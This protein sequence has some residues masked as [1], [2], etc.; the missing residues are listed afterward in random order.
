MLFSL[1]EIKPT[2]VAKAEEIA[3]YFI[4]ATAAVPA[5]AKEP[6]KT[7]GV[8]VLSLAV[9]KIKLSNFNYLRTH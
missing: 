5:T 7:A 2:I 3:A 1:E 4:L 9:E 6:T 8:V